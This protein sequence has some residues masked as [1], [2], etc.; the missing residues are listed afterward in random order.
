MICNGGWPPA[1]RIGWACKQGKMASLQN[2]IRTCA[3]YTTK[4]F[5]R[6]YTSSRIR[7]PNGFS[8]Q[9]ERSGKGLHPVLCIPGAL[10]TGESSF[11]PQMKYFGDK[12]SLFTIVTF[13]PRGYGKSNPPR[14]QFSIKPIHNLLQDAIDGH[15]LMQ[16]LG[17][18]AF[19]I[20]GWSDGGV[21]GMHLASIY[22]AAVKKLVIWGSNA[23]VSK[24][25]IECFEKTRDIMNWNRTMRE[26]F[27]GIY[28][29][30]FGPLWSEWIDSMINVFKDGG[31]LCQESLPLIQAPTLIL[32]GDRDP[33]LPSFHPV[34]LHEKIKGSKLY[35]F[36]LGKHDIH[37]KYNEE[38]NL[39]VEEF[40]SEQ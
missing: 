9:V 4:L 17:F 13:D 34:Y 8:F 6:T 15:S 30:D 29:S 32:H 38:F 33:L 18:D 20:L 5:S 37:L 27:E 22:P 11:T 1:T 26:H 12:G 7:L 10:C 14:R 2:H 39:V 19:S 21:A 35:K 40:L 36:P 25:D 24:V 31:N 23:F 28:G 16:E 3:S